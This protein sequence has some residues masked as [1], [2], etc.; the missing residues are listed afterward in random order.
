MSAWKQRVLCSSLPSAPVVAVVVNLPLDE[1][2]RL[3]DALEPAAL[4]LH[5]DESPSLVRRLKARD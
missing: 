5:G 3:A 4:Q 1:L 2:L